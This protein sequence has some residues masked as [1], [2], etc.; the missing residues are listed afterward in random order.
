MN[1][2][3]ANPLGSV[4][5]GVILRLVDEAGGVAAARHARRPAVTVAMDGMTFRSPVPIGSL[6]TFKASVNYAGTTSMEVGVRV[7]TEDLLTG[8]IRH[9]AT[10]Y[11]VYVALDP[12]GKPCPVPRL[13]PETDEDARRMATAQ[14]RM[15]ARLKQRK[16]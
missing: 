12:A 14:A 10:A 5:G 6:V 7:E 2:A 16:A 4:H 11:L 13:I 1:P 15:A 8:E 9:T 3:D